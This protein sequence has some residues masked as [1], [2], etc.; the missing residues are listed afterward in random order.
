[1]ATSN[2]QQTKQLLQSNP[3]LTYALFQAMVMM[4]LIDPTLVQQVM[5]TSAQ[6][7]APVPIPSAEQQRELIMRIMS[8]TPE[9]I[10]ALPPHQRDQ[11]LQLVILTVF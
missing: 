1:M 9:Q 3:S 11:V 10:N 5:S 2:P 6:A 4:N 7:A 8:F